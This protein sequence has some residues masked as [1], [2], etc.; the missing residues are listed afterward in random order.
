[1]MSSPIQRVKI[2]L[3]DGKYN[4]IDSSETAFSIATSM[5]LSKAFRYAEPLIMEPIMLVSI[6]APENFVGDI[7]G[8]INSKRGKIEQIRA[9][10]KK[11]EIIAEIPMSELFGYATKLRSISQGR[12]GYTME[13][14]HYE[15]VPTNIQEKI[16][17][18]VRGY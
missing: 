12:A 9:S 10:N 18:K 2:E 1:L 14:L 4:E 6:I 13:F 5:A 8:D 11:Q 16:L 17:K 7:I 3:I 15:I